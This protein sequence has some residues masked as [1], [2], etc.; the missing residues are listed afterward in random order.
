M[1]EVI[2]QVD[3]KDLEI[4]EKAVELINREMGASCR[5]VIGVIK[6]PH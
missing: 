6:R 2:V 1:I 3:E 4:A 5:A